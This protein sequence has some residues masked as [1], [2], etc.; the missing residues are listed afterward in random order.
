MLNFYFSSLFLVTSNMHTSCNVINCFVMIASL[1][2]R[3]LTVFFAARSRTWQIGV[4]V[5]AFARRRNAHIICSLYPTSSLNRLVVVRV[6]NWCFSHH[7]CRRGSRVRCAKLV[8]V[9]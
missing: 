5:P 9:V 7:R 3:S 4:A 6:A 2:H 1:A 8:F